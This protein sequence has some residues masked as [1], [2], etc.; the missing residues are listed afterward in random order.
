MT[1]QPACLADSHTIPGGL[2]VPRA[3]PASAPERAGMGLPLSLLA[4]RARGRAPIKGRG[5]PRARARSRGRGR[6]PSLPPSLAAATR[7]CARRR[8]APPRGRRPRTRLPTAP[9]PRPAAPSFSLR[10]VGVEALARALGS[11]SVGRPRCVRILMMHADATPG[12][13]LRSCSATLPTAAA[14]VRAGA[15][16]AP[17]R[18]IGHR[19]TPGSSSP[20]IMVLQRWPQSSPAAAL[21]SNSPARRM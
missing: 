18:E 7:G 14:S 17:K 4:P 3:E 9:A 5:A 20:C 13:R 16:S 1:F 21:S 19:A 6:A 8:P 2:L 15:D 11:G 12:S 10:R